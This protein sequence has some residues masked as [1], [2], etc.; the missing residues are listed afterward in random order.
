VLLS[1]WASRRLNPLLLDLQ[2]ELE[3]LSALAPT[4]RSHVAVYALWHAMYIYLPPVSQLHI[5]TTLDNNAEESNE[6]SPD[7]L[8][9]C[10]HCN[11][12]HDHWRR[13]P[14]EKVYGWEIGS[15]TVS[16]QGGVLVGD[17]MGVLS[18]LLEGR[19]EMAFA[20]EMY[21]WERR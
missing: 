14:L 8:A 9:L 5:T 21:T 18:E 17:I 3:R 20:V 11:E 7:G 4:L 19:K 13:R 10:S 12:N 1:T 2:A 15:T 16:R 6:I